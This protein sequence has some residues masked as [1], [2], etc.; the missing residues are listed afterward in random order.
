MEVYVGMFPVR[1]EVPEPGDV[2]TTPYMQDSAF[3]CLDASTMPPYV[4]PPKEGIRYGAAL[5]SGELTTFYVSSDKFIILE[6]QHTPHLFP[7]S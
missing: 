7:R 3:L 4:P 2:F 6:P 5:S 1:A